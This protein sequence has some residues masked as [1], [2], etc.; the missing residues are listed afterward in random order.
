MN[1]LNFF[2]G[3]T[4]SKQIKYIDLFCGMGS[5]HYSFKKLGWKCVMASPFQM[6]EKRKDL[7][8][9]EELCFLK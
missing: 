1:I 4:K 2:G 3:N 5:F 7:T 9:K 6:L 8:M